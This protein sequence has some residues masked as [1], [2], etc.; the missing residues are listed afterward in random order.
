MESRDRIVYAIC[1][2]TR[3]HSRSS[4]ENDARV[5][6][7]PQVNVTAFNTL[8][9]HFMYSLVFD[10]CSRYSKEL[11]FSYFKVWRYTFI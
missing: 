1:W 6:Y 7:T 5:E 8:I 4:R 10:S 2:P 3:K 11:A 9:N